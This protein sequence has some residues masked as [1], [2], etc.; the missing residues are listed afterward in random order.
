MK[1]RF[2][3]FALFFL[4]IILD[5]NE[6]ISSFYEAAGEGLMSA[7]ILFSSLGLFFDLFFRYGYKYT[8]EHR[9]FFF[10]LIVYL[11]VGII[12]GYLAGTDYS[13]GLRIIIPGVLIYFLSQLFFVTLPE[14]WYDH[15]IFYFLQIVF[16]ISSIAV[17]VSYF[18]EIDLVANETTFIE[19]ATGLYTNPNRAGNI[20]V[21]GQIFTLFTILNKKIKSN[22]LLIFLFLL[23][24]TS[25]LL[26]FSKT[27]FL[28][29][30]LSIG[31]L[32]YFFRSE[33]FSDF[34]ALIAF[35]ILIF[36]LYLVTSQFFTST[37][38]LSRHQSK[39]LIEFSQILAGELNEETT[40]G[41]S[42]LAIEG[43]DRIFDK[44]LI[45]Y[46]LGTFTTSKSIQKQPI[47]NMYLGIWGEAGFIVL[48]IYM[49][50]LL[51]LL[52]NRHTNMGF[53]LYKVLAIV[54]III[55]FSSHD[56][57]IFKPFMF[58]LGLINARIARA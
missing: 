26:T 29:S 28:L 4:V 21:I 13:N 16:C 27:A 18:Y 54:I 49:I 43:L 56:I 25:A 55:S 52:F 53:N 31:F 37:D 41:R 2:T 11:V 14:K 51:I 34:K 47:H 17:L 20:A 45:G 36:G 44:P 33:I 50:Y 32:L 48:L 39:I 5:L 12:S 24:F 23:H 10:F 19:R 9:A 58:F 8:Y 42:D 46:G 30:F 57:F 6:F 22:Y 40:T 38:T 3:V 35:I 15:F 7:I 1:F